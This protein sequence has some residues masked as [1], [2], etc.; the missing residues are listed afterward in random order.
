MEAFLDSGMLSGLL[1]LIGAVVACS[2]V[3][4]YN[5]RKQEVHASDE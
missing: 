2:P 4:P 1:F 5:R 3:M